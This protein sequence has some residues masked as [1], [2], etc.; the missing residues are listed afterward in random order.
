M[1]FTL[2]W[3]FLE[4]SDYWQ[5]D[6]NCLTPWRSSMDQTVCHMMAGKAVAWALLGFFLDDAAHSHSNTFVVAVKKLSDTPGPSNH[7]IQETRK[8]YESLLGD[9]SSHA[10]NTVSGT[11]ALQNMKQL[12][13]MLNCQLSKQS[14]TAKLWVQYMYEIET[15][16]L[17]LRAERTSSWNLH[18]ML[19]H[20]C[21][22]CLQLLVSLS[23]QSVQ[24]CTFR[25]WLNCMR[26]TLAIHT[27]HGSWFSF[28]E[29]VGQVLG[30]VYQQI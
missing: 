19:W 21:S 3:T 9:A 8:L 4:V 16:K 27:V 14:R 20:A 7:D 26:L 29:E 13:H 12:L 17:F 30:L 22:I 23:M 5:L 18:V 11:P 6:Q 2:Q 1:I 24:D 25:W 28:C 15:V 10:T